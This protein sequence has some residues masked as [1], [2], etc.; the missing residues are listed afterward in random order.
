MEPVHSALIVA[1]GEGDVGVGRVAIVEV[2]NVATMSGPLLLIYHCRCRVAHCCRS[3]MI[4]CTWWVHMAKKAVPSNQCTHV[5][6]MPSS[7]LV[8]QSFGAHPASS[9][10]SSEVW[11]RETDNIPV[12]HSSFVSLHGRLLAVGGKDLACKRT[13]AI[14]DPSS[15]SWAVISHMEIP[16]TCSGCYAAVVAVVGGYVD[17]DG[18][19]YSWYSRDSNTTVVII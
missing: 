10:S 5:H 4:R 2:L 6:W 8:D 15:I 16:R 3:V 19:Y 18:T 9:P 17:N 12:V 14:H 7:R 11:R 1:G 13:L